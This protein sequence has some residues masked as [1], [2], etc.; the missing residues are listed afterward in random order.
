LNKRRNARTNGARRGSSGNTASK[1]AGRRT[2]VLVM[3]ER[4]QGGA[5]ETRLCGLG[6]TQED[7][8]VWPVSGINRRLEA[9]AVASPG[10][11]RD[12]RRS[13]R[14]ANE[15]RRERECRKITHT[16]LSASNAISRNSGAAFSPQHLANA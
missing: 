16:T 1:P 12:E 13:A 4:N 5:G 14:R 3:R 9:R 11:D 10:T 2:D 7:E 15:R 6:L 8:Q